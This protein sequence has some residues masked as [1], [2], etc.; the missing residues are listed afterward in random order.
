MI[1][2]RGQI[3]EVPV[4]ANN[5]V[6]IEHNV[7]VGRPRGTLIL[8]HG[9][10]GSS[11]SAYMRRTTRWALGCGWGVVRMNL[12]NCGGSEALASTLYNAGQSDDIGQLLGWL[13]THGA[14][15]PFV[16]VGFS[17]GG[18][19]VLRHAGRP[20]GGTEPDAVVAIN[21]PVDL[22]R[23]TREIETP[24]NRPYQWR[25]VSRLRKQLLQIAEHRPLPTPV[26]SLRSIGSIRRFDMLYTAP[27]AGYV[28]AEAYYADASADAVMDRVRLP[29][30]ILSAHNDPFVPPG[31]YFD[32]PWC[33]RVEVVLSRHGGHCGFWQAQKPRFW[34]ASWIVDKCES[35]L[36]RQA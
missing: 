11:D 7:P 20:G 33:G 27:D 28:S 6:R 21:P 36:P 14:T 34:A 5:A 16:T 13:D 3:H 17:L 22:A 29:A 24:R 12:R 19:I 1:S 30:A 9:M 23:C 18:N 25:Y 4:A 26:L 31:M 2:D 10:A 35:L 15:R 32:R 8:V